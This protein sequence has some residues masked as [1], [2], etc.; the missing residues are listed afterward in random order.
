[1]KTR[2]KQLLHNVRRRRR[3]RCCLAYSSRILSTRRQTVIHTKE[4]RAILSQTYET[5]TQ[6]SSQIFYERRDAFANP[7]QRH[8]RQEQNVRL[9][10]AVL[11]LS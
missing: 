2:S 11:L 10:F 5:E 1:M 4:K 7:S 8:Y 9:G 6:S 3:R